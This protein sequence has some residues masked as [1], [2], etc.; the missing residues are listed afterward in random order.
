MSDLSPL[1]DHHHHLHFHLA[2]SLLTILTY[3][4]HNSFVHLLCS[5]I[6]LSGKEAVISKRRT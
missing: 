4:F 2:V 1:G 3:Y 6:Y 5:N